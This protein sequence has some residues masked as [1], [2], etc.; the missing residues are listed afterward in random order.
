M[1][2]VDAMTKNYRFIDY[3]TQGYMALVGALV[4]V[5]GRGVSGWYLYV[6]AH[7]V[8]IALVHRLVN[9]HAA[10]PDNRALDF[11]RHFYPILL[12]AGF[13]RETGELNHMFFSGFLDPVLIGAEQWLFGCQASVV[14]MEKLPWLPV[15][16][17][18][19]ASYFSYYIM[20]V[21][22]GLALYVQDRRRFFHYVS[23]VSFTFYVCYMIYIVVPAAGPRVF[24]AQVPGFANQ[25]D[26]PYYMVAF[27]EAVRGGPFF[28]IM[29]IIYSYFETHGAAFPSSHVAVALCSLYFSWR[30]V[31]RLRV[32]HTVAV[33]LLMTSTVYC[34][35]HYVVDVVAGALTGV[36]LVLVGEW[37]YRKAQADPASGDAPQSPS[38]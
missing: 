29:E 19:Y 5:F 20:I 7:A 10:R 13:Y 11:L 30:Y 32:V 17:L 2:L 9:A 36:G 22:V 24:W 4:L 37:I 6:L 23:I 15:S 1:F 21:G 12:Y 3:A 8:C 35:Y 26:L 18:L 33:V 31:P 27:P 34:R 14:F 28:R 25:Q 38:A 16:E